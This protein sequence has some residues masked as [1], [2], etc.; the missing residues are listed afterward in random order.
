MVKT[1]V[2]NWKEFM[3][4]PSV[5]SKKRKFGFKRNQ[6]DNLPPFKILETAFM[7]ASI[8]IA[9]VVL[10]PDMIH[11]F[12]GVGGGDMAVI[13]TSTVNSVDGELSGQLAREV[14]ATVNQD[15][16][17][18]AL[19]N[20]ALWITDKLMDGVIIYSGIV[21]MFGDRSK[22]INIIFSSGIGYII[23]RHHADIKNFLALL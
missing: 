15:S 23:I 7:T 17:W 11:Y 18:G 5:A 20:K 9:G 1:E 8:T 16:G 3:S 12:S 19:I 13:S 21:W 4:T 14:S 2:L 22:A 10:I 6:A